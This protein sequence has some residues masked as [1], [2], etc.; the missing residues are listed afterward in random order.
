LKKLTSLIL[1]LIVLFA[2]NNSF[3]QPKLI[4]HLTGG[5]DVPSANLGGNSNWNTSTPNDNYF[6]QKSGF[7]F[8][9]DGKYYLGKKGNFG[10][11]LGLN[12]LMF[13]SGDLA[14]TGS[15]VTEKIK[16]NS[17]TAGLGAEWGFLPK[18]K[19]NPFIGAEF[20]GNFYGGK[21]TPSGGSTE[22]TL[23]S[24]SRFGASFGAGVDWHVSKNI[25]VVIGG[26]Y[27]MMN[28]IGKKDTS[29]TYTAGSTEHPLW[30]KAYG[31]MNA[32]NLS[33]IQFYAGVSFYLMQPKATV[34]K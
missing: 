23:K 1:L 34:K 30:D 33:Y 18:G 2:V 11:T 8:G 15:T 16:F 20:T 31:T 14:I 5:Y 22:Q 21:Y 28:L 7:H 25:G 17:F 6:Y 26:K 27:A 13:N 3:A 19:A 24:G 32:M 9:A 4:I 10:I 29:D 12:Y